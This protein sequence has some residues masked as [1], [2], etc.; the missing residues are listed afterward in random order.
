MYTLKRIQQPLRMKITKSQMILGYIFMLFVILIT[1]V[2]AKSTVILPPSKDTYIRNVYPNTNEGGEPWLWICNDEGILY[3]ISQALLFFEL[4]YDYNRYQSIQLHFFT[5]LAGENGF[6]LDV[7][8]ILEPWEEMS[9]TWNTRPSMGASLFSQ[10][11]NS[12][13]EY[14]IDIKPFITSRIFSIYLLSSSIAVNLC[15]IPSLEN[16]S[17][18]IYQSTYVKLSDIELFKIFPSFTII[19]YGIVGLSL[20]IVFFLKYRS[21]TFTE[22]IDNR[23]SRIS[24]SI[25]R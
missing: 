21:R 9:V 22:L 17:S 10:V 4:P 16:N 19:V 3:D 25:C 20:T 12:D 18:D 2:K 8:H 7:F 24:R 5:R 13:Q 14:L 23:N 15:Q 6:D 11:V 1:P